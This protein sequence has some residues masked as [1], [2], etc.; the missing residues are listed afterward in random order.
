M[1]VLDNF[2]HPGIQP[3]GWMSGLWRFGDRKERLNAAEQAEEKK[4]DATQG[5]SHK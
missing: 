2:V 3:E 1:G 5:S 4:A